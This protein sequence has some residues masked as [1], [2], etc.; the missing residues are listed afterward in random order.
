[1]TLEALALLSADRPGACCPYGRCVYRAS[2]VRRW[3]ALRARLR[4][5]CEFPAASKHQLG[6][7]PDDERPCVDQAPSRGTLDTSAARMDTILVLVDLE[8][9]EAAGCTTPE[10]IGRWLCPYSDEC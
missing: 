5:M 4:E 2:K 3:L 6:H 9:A 10:Q 8:R 1:M 7:R